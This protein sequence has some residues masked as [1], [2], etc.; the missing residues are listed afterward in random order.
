M[1][2]QASSHVLDLPTW[3]RRSCQL[4]R[5]GLKDCIPFHGS[6]ILVLL[7]LAGKKTFNADCAFPLAA[8]V[9]HGPCAPNQTTK[10]GAKERLILVSAVK[11][12]GSLTGRSEFIPQT[13]TRLDWFSHPVQQNILSPMFGNWIDNVAPTHER[14]RAAHTQGGRFLRY[15]SASTE[16]V[17][18]R[19]S[20]KQELHVLHCIDTMPRSLSSLGARHPCVVSEEALCLSAR[21]TCTY[22]PKPGASY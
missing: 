4:S 5:R 7:S 8:H 18:L 12:L 22:K 2:A 20:Y 3:L 10:G 16:S 19:Q 15:E 1:A 21:R 11:Q 17:S 9:H 13:N 6:W 14:H